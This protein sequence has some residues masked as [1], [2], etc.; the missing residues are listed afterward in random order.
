MVIGAAHLDAVVAAMVPEP[1]TP[2]EPPVP[3]RRAFALVPVVIADHAV[4]AVLVE[5]RVRVLPLNEQ[6]VLVEQL[7]VNSP[8]PRVTMVVPA[9]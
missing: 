8:P 5:V 7:M 2:K 3:I 6:L 4:E 1:E 9:F